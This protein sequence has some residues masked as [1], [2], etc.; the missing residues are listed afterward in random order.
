LAV[1]LSF[2]PAIIGRI[3]PADCAT[4]T[5]TKNPGAVPL[6]PEVPR[7]IGQVN[8]LRERAQ[9]A[10]DSGQSGTARRLLERALRLDPDIPHLHLLLSQALASLGNRGG[11]LAR[12]ET[13][14]KLGVDDPE[15]AAAWKAALSAKP[16]KRRKT[17][18]FLETAVPAQGEFSFSANAFLLKR[19]GHRSGPS[20]RSRPAETVR[21]EKALCFR[22]TGKMP[23]M[24][25]LLR[26]YLAGRP[27]PG[28]PLFIALL[29]T[30]R[31]AE[32]FRL[33]ESLKSRHAGDIFLLRCPFVDIP[34]GAVN[35]YFRNHIRRLLRL[36]LSRDLEP[37]KCMYLGQIYTKL[38]DYDTA[39]EWFDRME[40]LCAAAD[41]WMFFDKAI[42]L[43]TA[44]N[45][46]PAAMKYFRKI[47]AACERDWTSACCLAEI[48]ICSGQEARGFGRF[49][50]EL[51]RAPGPR[52]RADILAWRG[53]MRLLRGQYG[54]AVRDLSS[55]LAKGSV[56]SH[57][58]L[59]AALLL[60]GKTVPAL[61]RLR[62]ALRMRPQ[63]REAAVW[64]GEALRRTGRLKEARR[65]LQRELGNDWA[66]VNLMVLECD[67]GNE[68]MARKYFHRIG[69]KPGETN[70]SSMRAAEGCGCCAWRKA[71]AACVRIRG[72]L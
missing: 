22:Q 28:I 6:R 5:A 4:M 57:C 8:A 29:E 68:I 70:L 13:A 32:A 30:H 53:E 65:V 3:F 50:E 38:R 17:G 54:L 36:R 56:F 61:E 64:Y 46:L 9:A 31:Y 1:K 12:A 58:W 35:A 41:G 49:R 48:D 16:G 67:A 62:Q 21:F 24:N 39:L 2:A 19:L 69:G 55:A 37:W 72:L 15:R 52:E 66:A 44:K 25:R 47:L 10:L 34:L 45:D 27:R 59:G 26:S 11:A 60:L 42:L 33:A 7:V 20:S 71:T 14:L 51:R 18:D 63:D 43:L 23:G 40:K